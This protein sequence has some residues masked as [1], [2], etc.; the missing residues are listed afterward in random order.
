MVTTKNGT[1]V[2]IFENGKPI[3]HIRPNV[4]IKAI[5][6]DQKPKIAYKN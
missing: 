4:V 3:A 2:R 5:A 1:T 6:G